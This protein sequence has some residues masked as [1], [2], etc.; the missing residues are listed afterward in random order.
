MLLEKLREYSRRIKSTP[1]MYKMTPIKWIISLD[2]DG[3]F[4]GFL[5][6]TSEAQ[7]KKKDKGKEYLAPTV[8][9]TS[10][11]KAILLADKVEYVLG[12][13]KEKRPDEWA[14]KCLVAFIE[15]LDKCAKGSGSDTVQ[16][17][18][19]FYDS[20]A[21]GSVGLPEGFNPTDL[22]TFSVDGAFPI[23]EPPVRDFWAKET[24][25]KGRDDKGAV[26]T[27]LVCGEE[28]PAAD[29]L[30]INTK[31]IPGG[32]T[33]GTFLVSANAPAFLS[34]DL[35]SSDMS[36]ICHECG[37][38]FGKALNDLIEKPNTH[39]TIGQMVYVFWTREE[40]G[41]D[42]VSL[43]Q[44]PQPEDV[45]KLL[46]KP[47]TGERAL[48]QDEA[49]FYCAAF[50]AS[51]GRVVVRD[52]LVTTLGEVQRN[53][54]R[55]F[56]AQSL[57]EWDGTE[58]A[59]LPVWKITSSLTFKKETVAP[60]VPKAILRFAFGGGELPLSLVFQ[61]VKRNRA[62][63]ALTRPRAA[64]IKM[65]LM[66]K[67]E[68]VNK[69]DSMEKVDLTN[70]N[71]AYLCGRLFGVVEAVQKTAMPGINATVTDRFYGTAST[72]PASV[73]G[74]LM[75]GC[76]NHISK[77]AKEKPG[78]CKY[79]EDDLLEITTS[80]KTFPVILNL[81]EQG[82]FALGF[83]HQKAHRKAAVEERKAR[84]AEE[85]AGE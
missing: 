22:F 4:K 61:A 72:A 54:A 80:L 2:K 34:Y 77:L 50:S 26:S 23:D 84:R 64:L 76:Q 35:K 15:L 8:G 40:T 25:G 27:C 7:G 79:L 45:K 53:L 55:Y 68:Y 83:Y 37:E 18:K 1:V 52:W 56:R 24:V 19:R 21:V 6:T 48:A 12:L 82:L 3:N 60:N 81:E 44:D 75:K 63:Q 57:V 14:S 74:R 39:I 30:P 29:K 33:S 67:K 73:F 36:P 49:L 70:D 32:Q 16:T 41:F 65:V 42:A 5:S 11:I 46:S 20:Y 38:A 85:E 66:S 47:L 51:G 9:R 31:G 69:E 17:V 13:D 71:P 28:K 59:P 43:F 78:A 10:G 58:G 62:E